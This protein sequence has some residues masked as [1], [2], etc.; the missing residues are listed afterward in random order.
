MKISLV[1][2]MKLIV[3]NLGIFVKTVKLKTTG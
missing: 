3:K 1:E 2:N